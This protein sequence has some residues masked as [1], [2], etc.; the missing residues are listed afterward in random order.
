MEKPN[1]TELGKSIGELSVRLKLL[2]AQKEQKY[3]EISNISL[4][5][6]D[7]LKKASELKA[8]KQVVAKQIQ[9]KKGNRDKLNTQSSQLASK[10]RGFKTIQIVMPRSHA[11]ASA[12]R[13]QL[14]N[15]NMTLQ[16]EVLSFGKEKKLMDTIRDLRAKLKQSE[17]AESKLKEHGTIRITLRSTKSEADAIHREIQHAATSNS[18]IFTE[19]ATVSK[20]I[21]TLKD[22]KL[23]L[24]AE[25]GSFKIQIAALNRGLADRLSSWSKIKQ[26]VGDSRRA[27]INKILVQKAEDAQEKLR[28]KKKLTTEDILAMQRQSLNR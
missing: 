6:N 8:S 15:L 2:D 5:L 9:V 23:R 13:S 4:E 22:A 24:R 12:L 7:L 26:T 20:R 1:V 19:L 16:T 14:D 11:P 25:I 18:E 17:L 28:T 21:A 27:S 3:Q 10:L